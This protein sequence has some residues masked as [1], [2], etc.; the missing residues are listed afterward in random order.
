MIYFLPTMRWVTKTLQPL[1]VEYKNP[2]WPQLS[3]S[4]PTPVIKA[5]SHIAQL[6]LP[7]VNRRTAAH[8]VLIRIMAL[9][10]LKQD[11]TLC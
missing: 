4:L 1:S 9:S 5:F 7:I 3:D 2:L 6:I 11:P 8:S 10:A